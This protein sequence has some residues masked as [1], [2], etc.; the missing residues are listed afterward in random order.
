LF[1]EAYEKVVAVFQIDVLAQLS[2]GVQMEVSSVTTDVAKYAGFDVGAIYIPRMNELRQF[3]V[4][5]IY[6]FGP[7]DLDTNGVALMS[8]R[9]RFSISLGASLG[10]LSSN[11]KSRVRSEN[12]FV[13][14]VG[15]R[16]NK[17]FRVSVGGA[18]YRD[19]GPGNGFLKTSGSLITPTVRWETAIGNP[20]PRPILVG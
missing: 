4:A 2:V 20:A 14:G 8:M 15:Y 16:L 13:Y 18:V 1:K 5:N 9:S 17:Y 6:P 19:S 11:A 7:V 10:D 12:A 3:L